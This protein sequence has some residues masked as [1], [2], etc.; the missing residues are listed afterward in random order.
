MKLTS[1]SM[2]I[3]H[4]TRQRKTYIRQENAPR[5]SKD[6]SNFFS[7][8]ASS[9]ELAGNTH[10]TVQQT[11][12]LFGYS[13]VVVVLGFFTTEV[14]VFPCLCLCLRLSL[15]NFDLACVPSLPLF[16]LS[17]FACLCHCLL[18]FGFGF[19]SSGFSKV[20]AFRLISILSAGLGY[21]C[22]KC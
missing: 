4:K 12:Q 16:E 1:S 14:M 8:L 6:K 3:E 15:G 18:W 2:L 19:G 21:F 5:Q 20:Q 22:S 10:L 7:P 9:L 17:C 13:A 11:M